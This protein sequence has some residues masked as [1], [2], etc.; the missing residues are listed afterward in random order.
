MSA[1]ATPIKFTLVG[2]ACTIKPSLWEAYQKHLS[3][4]ELEYNPTLLDNYSATYFLGDVEFSLTLLDTSGQDEYRTLLFG[5]YYPYTDVCLLFFSVVSKASFEN[6]TAK[7]N[8]EI[9]QVCPNV[10]KVLIGT[11]AELRDDETTIEKLA[12]KGLKPITKKEGK[13]L[14]KAINAAKYIDCFFDSAQNI[15]DVFDEALYLGMKLVAS[16]NKE[17]KKKKSFFLRGT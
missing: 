1:F 8:D 12:E 11:H 5:S 14:A 2:D 7:W 17:V 10:F 15:Q 16:K 13:E 3:V 9:M 6:V 4:T